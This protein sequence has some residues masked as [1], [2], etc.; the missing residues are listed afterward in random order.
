MNKQLISFM[1]AGMAAILFS[2]TAMSQEQRRFQMPKL[3]ARVIQAGEITPETGLVR[4][5]WTGKT[6]LF[7]GDSISDSIIARHDFKLYY[8]HLA[9][10]LGITPVVTAISGMEWSAVPMQ[11]NM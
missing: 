7:I 3:N 4:H 6:V 2:A 11:L 1:A 5:P 8:E 9:D 10:W